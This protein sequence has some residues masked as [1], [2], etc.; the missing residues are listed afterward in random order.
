MNGRPGRLGDVPCCRGGNGGRWA[1]IRPTARALLRRGLQNDPDLLGWCSLWH[2]TTRAPASSLPASTVRLQGNVPQR[3]ISQGLKGASIAGLDLSGR[4]RPGEYSRYSVRPWGFFGDTRQWSPGEWPRHEV[5]RFDVL[6]QERPALRVGDGRSVLP[7]PGTARSGRSKS[8]SVAA[9][10]FRDSRWRHG[11]GVDAR[12]PGDTRSGFAVCREPDAPC[13][14]GCRYRQ[15]TV[16]GA[17]A[18]LIR[19]TISRRWASS[20]IEPNIQPGGWSR[21]AICSS[22]A[23]LRPRMSLRPR[24]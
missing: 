3:S 18:W 11:R 1:P 21:S 19:R 23:E 9:A 4:S 17:P 6:E 20:E 7:R 22:L 8:G 13:G 16:S 5:T 15:R 24:Q 2:T 10:G 12:A 14:E